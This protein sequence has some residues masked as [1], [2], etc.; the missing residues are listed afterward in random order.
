MLV[1]NYEYGYGCKWVFVCCKSWPKLVKPVNKNIPNIPGDSPIQQLRS[2]SLL[3]NIKVDIQHLYLGYFT[4]KIPQI[5]RY[6][7]FCVGGGSALCRHPPKPEPEKDSMVTSHHPGH[8]V[9]SRF[10]LALRRREAAI[11]AVLNEVPAEAQ[12]RCCWVIGMDETWNVTFLDIIATGVEALVKCEMKTTWGDWWL[13]DT[14]KSKKLLSMW[15]IL[16]FLG[17]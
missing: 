17:V 12:H 13:E 16:G 5:L 15:W 11:F 10:L 9:R 4:Q 14:E 1:V 2:L 3:R 8:R 6:Y 7:F